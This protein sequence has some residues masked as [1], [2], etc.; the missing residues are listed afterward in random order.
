LAGVLLKLGT[1]GIIRYLLIFENAT[2]FFTP[3]V[4][5][6]ACLSIFFSILSTLRQIDLNVL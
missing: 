3:F 2:A 6:I 5:L 1:Y 4:L